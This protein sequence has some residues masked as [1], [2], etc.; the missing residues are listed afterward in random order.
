MSWRWT[1]WD[2]KRLEKLAAALKA[3]IA[4]QD[5]AE[6]KKPPARAAEHLAG[7]AA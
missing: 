6:S 5:C 2:Q 7:R 3:E 4:R 1:H